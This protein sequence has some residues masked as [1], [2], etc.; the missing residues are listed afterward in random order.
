MK[1]EIKRVEESTLE[2]F[3]DK[4]GLVMMV[5]EREKKIG[6][7]FRYYA[8]FKHSEVRE[9]ALLCGLTGNGSTPEDAIKDYANLIQMRMLVVNAMDTSRREIRVPRLVL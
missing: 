5:R 2:A 1:T 6:D 8:S 3:A 4:H 7:Q 9:G